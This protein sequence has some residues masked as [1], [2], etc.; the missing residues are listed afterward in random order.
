MLLGILE[1]SLLWNLSTG[2]GIDSAG[3]GAIRA[4]QDFN[5]ILSFSKFWNTKVLS[6]WI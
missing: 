2:K 1:A 3:E 5:F 4:G 6:K